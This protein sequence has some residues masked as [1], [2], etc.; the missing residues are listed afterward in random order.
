MIKLS[1]KLESVIITFKLPILNV[2]C[3]MPFY[4]QYYAHREKLRLIGREDDLEKMN[5][6]A[7]KIAR[8]VANETG[9][10]MAGNICNT[11][12]YSPGNAESEKA[13]REIFKVQ[14]N[15]K[16][17][18]EMITRDSFWGM[19]SKQRF[20]FWWTHILITA[21]ALTECFHIKNVLWNLLNFKVKASYELYSHA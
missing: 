5:R 20:F 1:L 7:L 12:L 13:C 21:A 2:E 8:Q 11:T 14:S 10:L 17:Y 15:I 18:L 9:T 3:M 6:Q 16:L 19:S 4:Y